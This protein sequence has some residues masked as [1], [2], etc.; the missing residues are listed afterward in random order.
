M[1]GFVDKGKALDTCKAYAMAVLLE[2]IA[3][4]EAAGRQRM[5]GARVS[6]P[7]SRRR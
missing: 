6:I 2:C 7:A 5:D 1:S 4:L 3:D